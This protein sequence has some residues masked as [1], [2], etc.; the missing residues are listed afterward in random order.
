MHPSK[1]TIHIVNSYGYRLTLDV[2]RGF[3]RAQKEEG[4]NDYSHTQKQ[5][6]TQTHSHTHKRRS[7]MGTAQSKPANKKGKAVVNQVS[8]CT[9]VLSNFI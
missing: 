1:H 9:T 6:N 5:H 2:E 4:I 3:M 8:I 7:T